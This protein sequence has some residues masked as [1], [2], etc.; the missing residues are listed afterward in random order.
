VRILFSIIGFVACLL[1][2]AAVTTATGQGQVTQPFDWRRTCPDAGH[3]I[4]MRAFDPAM[5]TGDDRMA[6]TR[7]GILLSFLGRDPADIPAPSN[8]GTPPP[9]VCL[10]ERR[11]LTTISAPD[12]I[13]FSPGVFAFSADDKEVS[14]TLAGLDAA[15]ASADFRTI[16]EFSGMWDGGMS[17]EAKKDLLMRFGIRPMASFHRDAGEGTFA[18]TH[19]QVTRLE[20]QPLAIGGHTYLVVGYTWCDKTVMGAARS[21]RTVW[22]ETA[23]GLPV[24]DVKQAASE[25]CEPLSYAFSS[26]HIGQVLA[27]R[28]ASP[29][30][31]A[32]PQT[33]RAARRAS[34]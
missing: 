15:G 7:P 4:I 27:Q 11:R 17:A 12:L 33:S 1:G 6:D 19:H 22:V 28:I 2:H 10:L 31:P 23:T 9:P 21:V 5:H 14:R 20:Q 16:T 8:A 34:R 3:R 25:T 24:L 18:I 32:S 26:S 13:R 29:T 30:P